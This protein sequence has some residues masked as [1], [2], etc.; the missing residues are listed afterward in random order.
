MSPSQVVT[1]RE[2]RVIVATLAN[3]PHGLMTHAM[4]AE[5]DA[6]V[7]EVE[8]DEGIGAVVLHGAHP[9]RFLA[10]Y[11]VEELLAGARAAGMRVTPGQAGAALHAVRAVARVPGGAGAIGRTPAAG[12]LML[13]RFHELF[14]RMNR[15]GATF[16]AAID[17]SAL[18]GGCELS[19]ACDLRYMSDGDFVIGQ[20]E[21]L[22]GIIPGGGGTQRLARLLGSGKALELVLEGTALSPREA[23]EIGLVNRVI[24]A[25]RLLDEAVETAHRLA[26]RP[27]VAVAAAKRAVYDG[28]SA[29]LAQGLHVERA[30]FMATLTSAAAARGLQAYLDGLEASGELPGYDAAA[31][32]HL[33]AGTYTDLTAP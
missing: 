27:R 12:M 28:G 13:E 19:L 7:S 21:I 29:G 2:G 11:D 5:L 9:E 32:E 17:G 31:R 22:L 33:Q 6:L 15:V 18:G 23:L 14:L 1:R 4:V 30:A 25:E 24:A 8:R 3:P 20:P 16:V 10:H 26:R